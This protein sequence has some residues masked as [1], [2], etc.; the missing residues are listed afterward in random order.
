LSCAVS[1][2]GSPLCH[3][4]LRLRWQGAGS[5]ATTITDNISFSGTQIGTLTLTQGGTCNGAGISSTPVCVDIQM[6]SG[7]VRLAGPVIGFSGN[8]NVNGTTTI[9]GVSFGSLSSPPGACGG[10]GQQTL[11]FQAS[12][13][14]TTASLLF[15]LSNADVSS[16]ITVGSIHVA[17]SFCPSSPTCYA[18]TTPTPVA[19]IPEPGTLG[20]LGTGLLV[21][22]GLARHRVMS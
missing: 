19:P 13:D 11:C 10:V 5:S 7:T 22:A 21:L 4:S 8:I 20:L 17:G 16:G 14:S 18:A 6:T 3:W 15:V 9:R 2:V 1:A 12:G